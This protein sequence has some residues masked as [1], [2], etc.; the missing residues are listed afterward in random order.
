MHKLGRI[1][2]A[3]VVLG[4]RYN[5]ELGLRLTMGAAQHNGQPDSAW[6]I[7]TF[8]GVPHTY[9]IGDEEFPAFLVRYLGHV[10]VRAEVESVQA[11]VSKP[12]LC[13]FQE[14]ELISWEIWDRVV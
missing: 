8:D 10:L 14:G 7:T 13:E 2:K 11:L 5:S 1:I 4:G 3:D 9:D 6:E 12:V